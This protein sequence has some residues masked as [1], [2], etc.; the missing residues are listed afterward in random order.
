M[1]KLTLLFTAIAIITLQNYAQTVTDI[2]GNVYNTVNIGTQLWLLENLKTTKLNDG[3]IIPNVTDTT[4]WSNLTTPGRCAYNNT[5][6]ADTINTYGLLYNWHT[7]NT[8]NLCPIGWHVPS[9]SEWISLTN[10]FGGDTS[11]EPVEGKGLN[12]L[13]TWSIKR[14]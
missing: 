9:D 12:S 5:T 13:E 7:V 1:K 4:S 6:N 11:S 14:F 8:G 3:T 10:S 2:D